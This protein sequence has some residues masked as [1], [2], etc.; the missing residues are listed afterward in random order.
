MN[1]MSCEK[2]S[3]SSE[4]SQLLPGMRQITSPPFVMDQV[5]CDKCHVTDWDICECNSFN[6]WWKLCNTSCNTQERKRIWFAVFDLMFIIIWLNMK[7]H[8]FVK[9]CLKNSNSDRR[10]ASQAVWK[11]ERTDWS[12]WRTAP[13]RSCLRRHHHLHLAGGQC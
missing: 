3:W 2:E 13:C 7:H 6:H 10:H 4:H 12:C 8:I 1:Q 11:L 9:N 5:A